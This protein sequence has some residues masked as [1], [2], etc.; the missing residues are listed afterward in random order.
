M[1]CGDDRTQLPDGLTRPNGWHRFT[2]IHGGIL[3]TDPDGTQRNDEIMLKAIFENRPL[4][5]NALLEPKHK[6]GL[7]ALDRREARRRLGEVLGPP[8]PGPPPPGP[9]PPP[10]PQGPEFRY[11]IFELRAGGLTVDGDE[12]SLDYRQRGPKQGALVL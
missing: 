2:P 8:P 1:A 12:D 6:A 5:E 11:F 4:I 3:V 9:P 10:P 7:D